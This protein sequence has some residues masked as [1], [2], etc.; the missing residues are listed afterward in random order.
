M[1]TPL[2][3]TRDAGNRAALTIGYLGVLAAIL[4]ITMTVA[5][6]LY[7]QGACRVCR[8]EDST[9]CVWVPALQGNGHGSPVLIV[10]GP[11]QR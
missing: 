11:D 10:N 4:L 5:T 6:V 2:D 3:I 9:S 7:A 1:R 8:T